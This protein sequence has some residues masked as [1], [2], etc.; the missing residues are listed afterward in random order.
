MT[1]SPAAAASLHSASAYTFGPHAARNP[2]LEV[3][4]T[5]GLG[6]FALSSLAGVPTRCYSGLAVS[7][8]PPVRRY[9]HLVSP[10]EVLR[11]GQEDIAL[12]ALEIAP[13]VFEGRGL[14]T[15][16]GATTWDLL[17]ER[18]QLVRGV[19]VRRRMCAPRHSG[20]V[21][22]LYEVQSRVPVTLTLGGFFVDR[23]MHHVHR[24]APKLSFAVQAGGRQVRVQGERETRATLYLPQGGGVTTDPLTPSPF[25]QR[26]YYRHDAARGEPDVDYAQGAALWQVQFPAGGGQVALVVQGLMTQGM[27]AGAGQSTLPDPWAAYAEEAMRRRQLAEQAWQASGV[28]DEVVATLAVAADAYLVQRLNVSTQNRS[29]SVIAGYPWFADWGRDAMIALSGLTLVTGRYEEARDILSTFLGALRRGLT[30]N[31]FHDDGTGAGFN[32]VDGALWLAVALERYART[33]GDGPFVRAALPQLRELL[34]WHVQGTDHG[35]AADPADGLLRAGEPGV[36]LTWMDVKIRDWVVTPR[37]GKPVE[38]QA[39]WLAALGAEARLSDVLGEPPV[40]A[41]LLSRAHQGFSALWGP[42]LGA[43]LTPA[44]SYTHPSLGPL[45]PAPLGMGGLTEMFGMGSIGLSDT[46]SHN[47]VLSALTLTPPTPLHTPTAP[48][49]PA[50]ALADLLAPDANGHWQPDWSVRP[51]AALALSLP[52][53]PA[54]AAQAD[55]VI[56]D[57]EAH[58]LTPVGLHTLSPLDPRY[59]GNYGGPQ[60]VRDAAYHQGTVWPWPL[61]AYVEVLL[62]RGEVRRA[63]AALAGLTGH[64]W[65]AGLGH[66]SEVFAGDSLTPGGCPFQAWSVAEVLRAHVLVARAEAAASHQP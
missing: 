61:G 40:Y 44:L 49:P 56:R 53:T 32:T 46:G 20:A 21:V 63:R 35:I 38:I 42:D 29:L 18:E 12:H 26:V 48:L 55:A 15:L 59:L 6:G 2:D 10:L 36:Q 14:E 28:Q 37:H 51:N 54:T 58:L 62:S 13:G 64:I 34:R 22:Y 16:T 7:Q 47:D 45:A 27:M 43:D 50:A 4:L 9:S 11:V 1:G 60:L 39:L 23:D 30:P 3:L 31:N 25:S 65:E 5:D 19:R 41:E 17:P 8:Q 66:V 33:T 24:A 57:I 52:D